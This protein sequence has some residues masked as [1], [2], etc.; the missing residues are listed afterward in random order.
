M[1]K[2]SKPI[3]FFGTEDFSAATLRTLIEAGQPVELVVTKPDTP[4]G[5]GRILTPPLVKQIAEAASIPVLQPIK[6]SEIIPE[7]KKL[8]A[9]I[10]V[11]VAY[12]KIIPQSVMDCFSPGI[13]NV[14]PSLL[15]K[16]RGPSPIETAILNGDSRTGIS[17]MQLSKDMD[18][19][20][21]YLQRAY[22]LTGTE[23]SQELYQRFATEGARLL[24]SA[25]PDITVGSLQP[26]EQDHATATY[27]R[28][29]T[30]N[31]SLLTPLAMTAS[32]C[33]RH[34]RA[35]GLYPKSK[36]PLFGQLCT[37]LKAHTSTA[38]DTIR[39]SV[40]CKDK[41]YLII[42]ELQAVNGKTMTGPEFMRGYAL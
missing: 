39:P 37:I 15:P 32:E 42:D 29:L 3:V 10:G 7:I 20:P 41:I 36:L 6:V 33:E 31:D 27:C 22:L 25:L 30:K 26:A 18:A 28:L 5:R 1:T 14:H 4:R 8:V 40:Q 19:G 34:I 24:L 17:I 12:G 23:T 21:V 38:A 11:L 13:I 2:I 35:F 16:Y 9:P